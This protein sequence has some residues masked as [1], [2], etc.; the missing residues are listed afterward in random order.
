VADDAAVFRL[1]GSSKGHEEPP[2][3]TSLDDWKLHGGPKDPSKQWVKFRSAY[4]LAHAWCGADG[5]APPTDFLAMLSAHPS[6]E[7]LQLLEGYAERETYLRGESG[8]PR[9]HD[10]LL[11]GR[12]AAG[13][14]VIGVEGKA[15]EEFDRPL[16]KRWEKAQRELAAGVE[17]GKATPATRWPDRLE[18]LARALLGQPAVVDGELSP[19]IKDV[20][21]QL[22][23]A[24][25]GTLIEADDRGA[26]LA[27]LVAHVFDTPL[28]TPKLRDVNTAAFADFV[29]RLGS[30]PASSVEEGRLYGPFTVPGG[31]ATRIPSDIPL[32][33]GKLTTTVA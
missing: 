18:R 14:V 24:T 25:A 2:S 12:C 7:G 17:A 30:I 26:A 3:I 6:L 28:T 23:S 10:L 31:E 1:F 32:L 22:L 4:E 33:L 29:S 11:V 8:G 15:D 9:V 13:K 16:W 20:P 21:Y 19:P 27:I 5:V